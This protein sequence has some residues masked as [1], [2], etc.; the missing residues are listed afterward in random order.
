MAKKVRTRKGTTTNGVS[1]TR[2]GTRTKT[3]KGK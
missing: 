1:K 2:P 3:R